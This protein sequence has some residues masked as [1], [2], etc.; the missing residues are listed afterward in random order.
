VRLEAGAAD[1][2]SAGAVLDRPWTNE[3]APKP[4][5][6]R[7]TWGLER[8]LSVG[9]I[10]PAAIFGIAAVVRLLEVS[11]FGFNSD[12]AVYAGQSAALAG[13]QDY[14]AMFGVFRAHPLLVHFIVSLVY[15]VTGVN[16]LAP[17]LV[18]VAAG[19]GMVLVAG[20]IA[21]VVRGR[22]AQLITML[23]V[24]LS[25]Y[26]VIV[27]RQLLLDG[28]M[29]FFFALCVL[30][31]ALYVRSPARAPLFAAAFAAGLAFLAK[32]T[33][34]LMV[35]AI[36]VFFLLARGVRMRILD[37][38][39]AGLVYAL[40]IAP[41]PLSLLL[42]GGSKTA[43]QFFIWQVFR[44]SNHDP[45]FYLTLIPT[46]GIPVVAL[47][48]VGLVL[49]L[50]RRQPLDILLVSLTVVMAAFFQ[51]W[52]VKGFQY[53]LPV[54][55]PIAILAADGLVAATSLAAR[56]AHRLSS[57]PR[58]RSMSGP[59]A[60]ATTGLALVLACSIV[61]GA[62]LKSVIASGAPAILAT[63]SGDGDVGPQPG[64][65]APAYAFVAGTGGLEASRPVGAWV[66]DHTLP[67]S[68]FLTVGASFA[69]VIQFYGG[70]RARA[71]SVSPNPL[72][73]NPTYEPVLNADLMIRT[74]AIQYLVYDSY[75]A[76]RTPFFTQR[77]LHYMKKYNGI[78]I[79][80]DYQPARR[81]NGKTAKVPVVLIYEVHP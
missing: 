38:A 5:R 74:N 3:A 53:L 68:N 21:A 8:V 78:L 62:G 69:N 23:I 63:D 16:D 41:F 55:V 24:A 1:T 61:M 50:R 9:W 42:S 65:A 80:A 73:R 60:A 34:L 37:A 35:P 39:G 22:R 33:A 4:G 17:R 47:A 29:A 14:A 27:S 10:A 43:Q 40:T 18:C 57:V 51:A 77:L 26:P 31:L 58:L 75:S 7:V 30:F 52:P 48:L 19:L 76:A 15:R 36:V 67:S 45:G 56:E 72:H 11:R 32:E 13:H 70:R 44:R 71:L 79:Y 49:A 59:S 66:R 81:P 64:K 2:V 46:I 28:P 20:A 25:P 54:T 6:E 12:E